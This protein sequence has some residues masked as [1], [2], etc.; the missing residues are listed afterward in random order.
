MLTLT[1]SRDFGEVKYLK[2][3]IDDCDLDPEQLVS[4]VFVDEGAAERQGHDQ[5]VT[6]KVIREDKSQN[7][8]VRAGSVVPD[9]N[10]P[11]YQQPVRPPVPRFEDIS[12]TLG[13]RSLDD[14]PF[15]GNGIKRVRAAEI[16]ESQLDDRVVASIENE[17]VQGSPELVQDTQNSQ[18]RRLQEEHLNG[19]PTSVERSLLYTQNQQHEPQRELHHQS[20]AAPFPAS[21][22]NL[23]TG[24][25]LPFTPPSEPSARHVTPRQ[26]ASLNARIT[27]RSPLPQASS[28]SKRFKHT[29]QRLAHAD[30]NSDIEDSQMSPGSRKAS[31]PTPK[32]VN[33]KLRAVTPSI[34]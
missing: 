2:D 5:H 23:L 22:Q 17:E 7:Y 8:G 27:S 25:R 32:L 10:R 4:D 24:P 3:D 11:Q 18:F 33:K 16:P 14:D 30:P 34:Y 13:K 20:N 6:F 9:L 28:T 31:L 1:R 12:S 19:R 29:T 26:P 21:R 15:Q